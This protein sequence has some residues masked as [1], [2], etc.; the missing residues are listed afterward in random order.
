MKEIKLTKGKVAL[1]DDEDYEYLSRWRWKALNGKGDWC[2]VRNTRAKVKSKYVTL[3]MHRVIMDAPKG[4][5]VDHINRNGLD[6]RRSNLRLATR[7]ENQRN[8]GPVKDS[9]SKYKGVVFDK[10]N[11]KWKAQINTGECNKFLG[12]FD[13]PEEAAKVYDEAAKKYH[14]AFAWLNKLLGK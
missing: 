2:A 5:T 12:Y 13:T 9:A 14:G 1:I 4:M 6:N 7:R 10:R 8:R 3:Y 11:K